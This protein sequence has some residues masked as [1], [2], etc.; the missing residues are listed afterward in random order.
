V[1]Q[2]PLGAYRIKIEAVELLPDPDQALAVEKLQSLH[3]ALERYDRENGLKGWKDRFGLGHRRK[4][5]PQGLYMFGGVGRGKSMLMDLFFSTA[6]IKNKRRVHFH[7]FMQQVH[8]RL[9][10]YRRW[11]GRSDDPI[12]PIAKRFAK[13]ATLLCF[14]EFQVHDIADAM[15]LSRLF[16]TLFD[17]GVV[18]VVTSNRPPSDLYKDGLQRALFLPFI[19]L[20]EEKLDLLMLDGPTDYRRETIQRVGMYLVP[21]NKKAEATLRQLFERL[22]SEAKELSSPIFVNGRELNLPLAADGV[23]LSSFNELCCATLGPGDYLAIAERYH[24]L[25]I[26]G[27][28]QLGSECRNE[29]KR[30]VILIDALYE[31]G[32]KLICSADVAP[33][34]LYVKGDGA[35]EF[36]RTASR[37]IEMQSEEYLCKGHAA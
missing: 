21:N 13:D 22:T 18:V 30:F 33:S 20:I 36:E 5:P 15:I 28:P 9:N 10:E 1:L 27:I 31:N 29:A 11:E 16:K 14:D 32:V 24:T 7:A 2:S 17:E 25:I 19:G 23:A 4:T 34:E 3:V 12:P 6:P 35:F 26:L 37:L 8:Q